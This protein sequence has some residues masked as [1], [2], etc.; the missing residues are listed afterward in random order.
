M[1]SASRSLQ[2]HGKRRDGSDESVS[3][4]LGA[5]HFFSFLIVQSVS[6]TRTQ[7]GVR[8][9]R[10]HRVLAPRCSQPTGRGAGLASGVL[11]PPCL[12]VREHLV[13]ADAARVLALVREAITERVERLRA[14]RVREPRIGSAWGAVARTRPTPLGVTSVRGGPAIPRFRG[15]RCARAGRSPFVRCVFRSAAPGIC[16]VSSDVHVASTVTPPPVAPLRSALFSQ[17]TV[18]PTV[19]FSSTGLSAAWAMACDVSSSGGSTRSL[20]LAFSE[21]RFPIVASRLE[22]HDRGDDRRGHDRGHRLE[23]FGGAASV[24]NRRGQ[25]QWRER[26]HRAPFR[27][28]HLSSALSWTAF[29]AVSPAASSRLP[30]SPTVKSSVTRHRA[31]RRH[32][33]LAPSPRLSAV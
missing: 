3:G 27:A 13:R 4:E 19:P 1:R 11:A 20:R 31:P 5:V 8:A 9:H 14:G 10:L 15:S 30:S 26:L 25:C 7:P 28:H 2:L 33:R 22:D 29:V 32:V 6:R 18:R 17:P 24:D 23:R 12:P 16:L 21:E